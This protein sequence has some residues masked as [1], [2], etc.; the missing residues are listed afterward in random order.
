MSIVIQNILLATY[1]KLAQIDTSALISKI[2][3]FCGII[4]LSN[5]VYRLGSDL[6]LFILH[7]STLPRFL[8]RPAGQDA[9]ALV[10][11]AS[12]GIGRGCSEELLSR[13]F[14]VVLHGRNVAK[15][16][17]VKAELLKLFPARKIRLAV[18]DVTA[19][20]RD[21]AAIEQLVSTLKNDGLSISVLVNNVG[22]MGGIIPTWLPL[23]LRK[24][25]E[26]DRVLDMN[27]MFTTQ[28]T[29]AMLP[30]LF[31]AKSAL[32]V[33]IG[34]IVGKIPGAYLTSYSGAKAYIGMWSRGLRAE[35]QCDK[36]DVEVLHISVGQVR[37]QH[38][39]A[40]PT[41]WS[42][43]SR[44][45]AKAVLDCVGC[46]RGEVTAYWPHAVQ[47]G[48]IGSLPGNW[49]DVV[50]IRLALQ[51]KAEEEV[52]LKKGGKGE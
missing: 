19:S 35:M 41:L 30:L 25:E 46:G 12:D 4:L 6:F 22:G 20:A 47:L 39:R 37:A 31:E 3:P 7:E 15:L 50:M 5:I 21:H 9:W 32:I 44:R 29:R 8:V 34:S 18:L 43:S 14:N 16:E 51:K 52:E 28:L 40:E 33:N 38:D 42:P 2:L 49:L 27:V 11:G 45:M 1:W 36:R 48:F 10:T 13:G 23:H 24:A 17:G 26:L